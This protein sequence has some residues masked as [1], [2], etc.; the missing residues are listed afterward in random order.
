[1][2]NFA[3]TPDGLQEQLLG[4]VVSQERPDLSELK[5]RLV[6][7]NANMKTQ[8]SDIE[9]KILALLASAGGDIL[10]DEALINTLADAKVTSNEINIK[11]KEAEET[12]KQIDETRSKYIPVAYSAMIQYFCISSMSVIDPMYQ[13]SLTW[14]QELFR[15]G[16]GNTESSPDFEVRMNNLIK[17]FMYSLYVNICRSLFE[18]HKLLFSFL[19]CVRVMIRT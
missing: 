7:Q 19:L 12:E 11:L 17:Y 16:I 8:M 18:T 1:L 15:N 13:Y 6:V 14:F 10:E 4:I 5:N 9:S 3:I 2:L